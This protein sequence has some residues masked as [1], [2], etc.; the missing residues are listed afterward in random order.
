MRTTSVVCREVKREAE[1]LEKENSIVW[2]VNVPP[3]ALHK[4][5]PYIYT[6]T[7]DFARI[8]RTIMGGFDKTGIR[9]L[10]VNNA[11]CGDKSLAA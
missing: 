2:L 3:K 1:G 8:F 5:W 11:S 6:L 7:R 10:K 4:V 9:R